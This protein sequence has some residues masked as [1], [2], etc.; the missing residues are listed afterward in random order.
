[1]QIILPGQTPHPGTI[2]GLSG[3]PAT[4]GALQN[5]TVDLYATD[6]FWNPLSSNDLVRIVS[7]DTGGN[8]PVTTTLSGGFAQATVKL[9]TVGSQTLTVNDLSNGTVRSMTTAGIMVIPS[10]ADHFEFEALAEAVVA[11]VA[12]LV[13]IRA[14]DAAGNTIADFNGD[15]ILTANTGP[16]SISTEAAT[17]TNGTWTGIV[18]FYGAGGAVQMSCSDYATPPHVGTSGNILVTPGPFVGTQ[19]ILPGQ[20]AQGGTES[21]FVGTPETQDAGQVFTVQIRAVDEFFNRVTGINDLVVFQSPDVNIEVPDGVAFVNG[22]AF[23]P[24][25]IYLAGLQVL[26]VADAVSQSIQ[27][28]PSQSFAVNPGPFSKMLLLAPGETAE[29]GSEFGRA[30]AATDQSITYLFTLTAVSTDQWFNQ[31]KGINDIVHLTT[32]DPGAELSEDLALVDGSA[33]LTARLA[34]GGF[35]QFTLTSISTPSVTPSTT[36]VRAISSGLHLEADIAETVVQAGVSFTLNVYMVNDAG[37]VIQEINSEVQITVRNATTQTNG[38]GILSATSF[39]LLQGQRSVSLNYTY[40]EPIIIEVTD[41]SGSSPALTGVIN[42][43][44][45]AP[46]VISLRSAPGWVRANATA[47]ISARITDAFE[48][49][50]P[51]LSVSFATSAA[52]SGQLGDE[53]T[54]AG[55]ATVVSLTDD[56]GVAQVQYHSPR[57]TQEIMVT[58]S[59]GALTAEYVL[60]TALVDPEAGGGHITNYPN[61]FHPDETATT[62]AYV[63]DDNASVR[64]RVYTLSG[65][66][67]LDRRYAAGSEGGSTGLNEIKWDG[68]NG[69]GEPVASGGYIAYVE[70]EGNGATQHVMRRKI[71]VVW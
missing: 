17:F 68:R 39:Q 48:N 56:D 14:T 12:T 44:P 10:F 51:D 63:L 4:Q 5:F 32:T 35:Q 20:T 62:I 30:G 33:S 23:I 22:E 24:V 11:G 53:E 34:T 19:V 71:G 29:A 43:E 21:G 45:G 37:S 59:S 41:S 25:T 66:L 31:V 1:M 46:T 69:D 47:L 55:A 61:P 7:S 60:I 65:G 13:S 70:A 8:T 38:R 3:S 27:A 16:G 9:A 28:L 49:P 2:S 42:V 57:H 64:L 40:A 58:A 26:S 15:V 54:K 36:Q 18:E 67:V 50:I 6:D 52:D